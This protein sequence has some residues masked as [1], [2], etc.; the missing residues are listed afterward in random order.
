MR[1]KLSV[2]LALALLATSAFGLAGPATAHPVTVGP[3]GGADAEWNNFGITPGTKAYS[4]KNVGRILRNT[5]GQGEYAWLDITSDGTTI[6]ATPGDARLVIT[7]T[8]QVDLRQFRLT[9]TPTDLYIYAQFA[10][11]TSLSGGAVPELQVAIDVP[12]VNTAGNNRFVAGT[13]VPTS[14]DA[15]LLETNWDYLV[16]T[17]FDDPQFAE[18][19]NKI[20]T[21]QPVV[22]TSLADQL[23]TPTGAGV[24]SANTNA[25]E[26]RTPTTGP[27][28]TTRPPAWPCST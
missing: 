4:E 22:H 14:T 5:Q 3:S 26:L 21:N 18:G 17:R 28:R 16:R 1:K 11:L 9:G 2:L 25:I 6:P 13:T 12:G 10:G 8:Q 19:F 23:G 24:L 7:E 27:R 20:N 15:P